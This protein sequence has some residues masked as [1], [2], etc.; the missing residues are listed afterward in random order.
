MPNP[1]PAVGAGGL[2]WYKVRLDARE[3]KNTYAQGIRPFAWPK[4]TV[5][6][7]PLHW[8]NASTGRGE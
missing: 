5:K 7:P 3:P 6:P 1:N 4:A 2:E 8:M